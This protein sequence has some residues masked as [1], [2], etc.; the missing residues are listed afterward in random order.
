MQFKKTGIFLKNLIHERK[1][2]SS[3][4]QPFLFRHLR[5]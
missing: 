5:K 1:T 3:K 2:M 4:R